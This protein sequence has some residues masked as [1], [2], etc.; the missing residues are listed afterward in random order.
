MKESKS[1]PLDIKPAKGRPMLTWVGKR[2]L[3]TLT[4]YPA[5]HVETFDPRDSLA[6]RPDDPDLWKDWPKAY[7]KGGLLLHGDNKEVLAHLLAN[8]FRGKVNLVYIDPPF[9]SGA[10]YVRKVSLR[11]PKGT[12]KLDGES[13]SLGEQLQYTDIWANDNY[14]QFMYERLLMFRELLADGGCFFLHCDERRQ[15]LLRCL[16]DEAF[17][18]S[19]FRNQVARV[20][21]NPKNFERPAFGNIHDLLIFYS[22]G[23]PATWNEQVEDLDS[24]DLIR[25]FP[26][27]DSSGRRYTTVPLHAAGT[28]SGAT[29][30]AWRGVPPPPG[31]HWAYVPAQL[32]R[33][34]ADGLIEWSSTGNPRLILFADE[35][36]SRRVQDIWT[37]KD[38]TY[39]TYPTEKNADI[40]RRIILATTKEGDLVL[41][42]FAGSGTTC[43]TAQQLGRRWIGCDINK[44]AIQTT[45]KRLMQ[46][47]HEQQSTAEKRDERDRQRSIEGLRDGDSEAA[48]AQW[49]FT[50]LR[51]NDYDL[52]IKTTEAIGLA[53]EHLGVERTRTDRFFDGTLGKRLVKI[54]AFD[55]PLTPLDL[56]ELR[57][58]LDARP[59]EDRDIVVAALGCELAARAWVEDWNRLRKNKGAANRIEVLELRSDPGVGGFFTH[60]PASAEVKIERRD[61]RLMVEVLDFVSPSI[62]QRLQAQASIVHPLVE[63]FR[64]MIDWIEIDTAYDGEVFSVELV[65]L[66]E[67]RKDLIAGRYE[68][69]AP[70]PGATVAVKIVDMLGEEVLVTATP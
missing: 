33:F 36:G 22:K 58:E 17:G 31:R 67:K 61:G 39:P 34:E 29:G 2:P 68:L 28:R 52:A 16:L 26:L 11:G 20:K 25:L 9:D 18:E 48:P 44:G 7:P 64:A 15:H 24:E 42:G 46:V 13:Y 14:L 21:C 54:V 10:D 37:M 55:H 63:D 49:A 35:K 53:C 27:I 45:A 50:V 62:L 59:E 70:T 38:P 6:A 5:Q 66:P 40:L 41:D 47:I 8:G 19:S 23:D 60:D 57:Q 51:V 32:E 12:A 3:R 65:D 43:L 69:E 4:P 56:E 30:K 1:K